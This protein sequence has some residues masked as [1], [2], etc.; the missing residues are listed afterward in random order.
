[1]LSRRNVLSLAAVLASQ[2]CIPGAAAAQTPPADQPAAPAAEEGKK[3]VVEEIIVTGSRVRRKDLTTPAP[4]TVLSRE[5]VAAAGKVSVGDFLQSLPEQGNAINAQYNNGGDGTTKVN[6][7]SL[8]QT[9]TLVLV[10]GR[11]MVT[12]GTTTAAGTVDLNSIPTAAIERIEILK[13]GAS[14]VYGSDAVAGVVNI[15]TRRGYNGTEATAFA[16]TS[17]KSDGTTYDLSVTTGTSSD[18]GSL[19]L[20]IG[21][22]DQKAVWAG[23]RSWTESVYGL[24]YRT[25]ALRFSGSSATPAGTFD[26]DTASC[27]ATPTPACQALIN[28]GYTGANSAPFFVVDSTQPGG[29]RAYGAS[30][31]YNFEPDNYLYTPARRISLYSTGD[32]N[33][34]SLARAFF[35]ASYVNRQSDQ[36]LAPEP[37]FIINNG[38]TLSANS[39]YNPYGVDLFDVRRRLVEFGKRDF[40]QDWDTFRVVGGLDGTLP[41]SL[42]PLKGWFWDA[43]L[44]YGRST[45]VD[46][47]NGTLRTTRI[48]DALGPSMLVGGVP[49]CVRTP[50]DATTAIS[51]CVPLNLF[52]GPGSI[53]PEQVAGLGFYG[54]DQ[55]K[56]Q[57]TAVQA[58][59]SGELFRLLSERPAALAVGYEYRRV[60]GENRP[61]PISQA[62]EN[63]GNN[64]QATRGGYEVN[65]GYA[66]LSIPIVSNMP[67]LDDLEVSLAGRIFNYSTF[68][69]DNTYKVGA[70]WR[71]IRDVTIRGTYST[72]FRA[73]NVVELYSGST[74]S[75]P[76]VEDPCAAP[77]PGSN[78]DLRCQAQ[79]VPAGGNGDNRTQQKEKLGGNP[80]LK[81]ETAKIYTVGAVFEPTFV[82]GLSV[83]VDYYN[84]DLK[85]SIDVL[86]SG[87]ILNACYTE[88]GTPQYCSL[89]H[90]TS[91]ASSALIDFIDDRNTNVGGTRT[92]GID[93]A[94]RY[95]LPTDFGRFN[96]IFDGTWLQKYDR[97]E[98]DGHVIHNKGNY[99]QLLAFPAVKFNTGVIWG[100]KN[101]GAGLSWKY[102]GSYKE[103]ANTSGVNSGTAFCTDNFI[104]PVAGRQLSHRIQVYYSFDAFVS[105]SMPS[106]FGKTNLTLG[107]TNLFDKTPP[108]IYNNGTYQSDP[109]TYDFMGRFMYVRL[110]HAY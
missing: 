72:A 67:G 75:F 22:F 100:L 108:V 103:C 80:D 18:R 15:I 24:N 32:A 37:L 91:P 3:S 17:K 39:M 55:Y 96:M 58:N 1:M 41:D 56:N 25:G 49:T 95:N 78:V 87:L 105:Y 35:E 57:I 5:Q 10:N 59:T 101:L 88:T 109:S 64:F 16:G 20:T 8:G 43:S 61:N 2:L 9:R 60:S 45:G 65:E 86:G 110:A 98:A 83:T 27:G 68:G 28:A 102:V 11:R 54:A 79:G 23:D 31:A 46:S 34:G 77:T 94:A 81:A 97:E 76:T 74:D 29:A 53:T 6:L 19:Q 51:G 42:G 90:R 93:F 36:K 66:E 47:T 50:G 38:V 85:K 63:S 99:D 30:D 107:M 21:Y 12:T 69:S 62:G 84:V 14:A 7:R 48:A 4:V 92:A 40:N 33:L 52:G 73:P 89:I 26:L 106:S 82:K 71:P 104:D 70:R 13:D 44:N